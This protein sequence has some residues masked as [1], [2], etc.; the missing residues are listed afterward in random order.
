M[1]EAAGALKCWCVSARLHGA[2][3]ENIFGVRSVWCA[4]D[5]Q[6]QL[7]HLYPHVWDVMVYSVTRT[8]VWGEAITSIWPW[9]HNIT[10]QQTVTHAIPTVLPVLFD[11]FILTVLPL[12]LLQSHNNA[13]WFYLFLHTVLRYCYY[14]H[15]SLHIFCTSLNYASSM[16]N[17]STVNAQFIFQFSSKS[18]TFRNLMRPLRS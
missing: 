4:K 2:T 10:P 7:S 5:K 11:C 16:P 12:C 8:N 18:L 13:A 3:T 15:M 14:Q 6:Q 1:K 17:A 9:L